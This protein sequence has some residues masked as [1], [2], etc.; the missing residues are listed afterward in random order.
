MGGEQSLER[1]IRG[2]QQLDPVTGG[3]GFIKALGYADFALLITP[4][5]DF[6]R[7]ADWFKQ[8]LS[9]RMNYDELVQAQL[10]TE[11]LL[12]EAANGSDGEF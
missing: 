12:A 11:S 6:Y 7:K 4:N 10:F 5:N 9:Q 2:F 1:L 8:R 3:Q